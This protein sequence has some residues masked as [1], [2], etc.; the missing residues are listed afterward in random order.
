MLLVMWNRPAT[1]SKYERFVV[2]VGGQPIS[3]PTRGKVSFALKSASNGAVLL[4][5]GNIAWSERIEWDYELNGLSKV[6][7]LCNNG[8]DG[9]TNDVICVGAPRFYY[10]PTLKKPQSI[11]GSSEVIINEC[12][13][14]VLPLD[15][16]A[17]SG[18]DVI[19][20]LTEGEEYARI[21]DGNKLNVFN[22]PSDSCRV[23]VIAYQPGNET[24]GTVGSPFLR[25]QD[26]EPR[27]SWQG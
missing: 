19:Y 26:C 17:E 1:C 4:N 27:N 14:I 9:N 7:I 24:W 22:I 15:A 25:V 2:D 8:G 18:L 6:Y 21:E 16:V 20:C 12:N 11:T 3:N 23:S 5:S 10:P 13:P